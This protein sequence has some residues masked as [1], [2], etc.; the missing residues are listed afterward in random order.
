MTRSELHN[1]ITKAQT[2]IIDAHTHDAMVVAMDRLLHWRT[3]ER[4]LGVAFA[5]T[6]AT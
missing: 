5:A 3:L 4:D 2:D 1:E 6:H